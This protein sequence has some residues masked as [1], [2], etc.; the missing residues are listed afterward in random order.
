MKFAHMADCHIGGWRDPKLRMLG[1]QAFCRAIDLCIEKSVDFVLIAG[2]LFNTSLPPIDSLKTAAGK[3]KELKDKNIPAYLIS[4]SHDYSPSGKTMLDV[5]EEAGLVVNVA[6][7]HEEQ[8]EDGKLRLKFTVD[9]K[10][11]AK[12]TGIPGRRAGLDKTFYQMLAREE[13]EQE[14]GFKIF[15]FHALIEELKTKEFAH[16]DGTPASLLP[17][18]FSYYAGGHVHIVKDVSLPGYGPIVYPGPLFPNSFS[19]LEALGSGGFYLVEEGKLAF[20]SIQVHNVHKIAVKADHKSPEQ[21]TREILAFIQTREF[22]DTIVTLRIEG[23][24]GSGK[25]SDVDFKVILSALYSRG[26]YFVMKNTFALKSKEYGEV[27][28]SVPKGE[29]V[30]EKVLKENVGQMPLEGFNPEQQLSLVKQMIQALGVERQEGE[31]VADFE[32]RVKESMEKL[33]PE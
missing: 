17:K 7:A 3:L 4:G 24:L 13:L 12:I 20:E 25:P 31:R 21:V 27:A 1:A 16:V 28:V 8:P 29:D 30:E 18:N 22:V 9:A 5:L 14:P 6:R 10:T 19:E 11:G 26:A 33:L 32:K 23:V 15:M 2:D